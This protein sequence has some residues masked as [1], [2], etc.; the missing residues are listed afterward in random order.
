MGRGAEIVFVAVLYNDDELAERFVQQFEND[1]FERGGGDDSTSIGLVLVDNSHSPNASLEALAAKTDSS[2]IY[3]FPGENLG[4]LNAL[5][6]GVSAALDSWPELTWVVC[7]NPD[8]QLNPVVFA[9]RLRSYGVGEALVLGPQIISLSTGKNQNPYLVK[10]PKLAKL[11]FL[12]NLYRSVHLTRWY[13]GAST[14]VARWRVLLA[15]GNEAK[16]G[17]DVAELT[18]SVYAVHGSVFAIS[19]EWLDSVSG[20]KWPCFLFAEELYLA[21][22]SRELGFEV[23]Y[24]TSISARHEEHQSI[25]KVSLTR[26]NAWARE[27]LSWIL[28]RFFGR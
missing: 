13:M 16:S 28:M 7:S 27:S 18:Q 17:C 14:T 6:R 11:M 2:F 15:N 25:S 3:F 8:I 9:D 23:R 12:A 24:D 10:R 22:I 5:G 1:V 26:R 4:Y 21:E 19:R 20:L